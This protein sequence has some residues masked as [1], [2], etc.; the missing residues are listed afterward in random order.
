MRKI[1]NGI[2]IMQK[3]S[4]L[5]I[6]LGIFVFLSYPF[7]KLDFIICKQLLYLYLFFVF[8]VLGYDSHQKKSNIQYFYYV[9]MLI[10]IL[11][12]LLLWILYKRIIQTNKDSPV[13]GESSL[14]TLT[15]SLIHP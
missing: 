7:F 6:V 1:F 12:S 5:F 11:F 3:K 4:I 10:L 8:G 14:I 13:L 9:L 15:S 2:L